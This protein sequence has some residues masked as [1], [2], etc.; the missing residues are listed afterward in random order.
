MLNN[1]LADI[2]LLLIKTKKYYWDVVG[3]QFRTL[4]VLWEERN[5]SFEHRIRGKLWIQGGKSERF[6]LSM[7]LQRG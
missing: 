1:C 5:S 3:L 2:Y 6:R 7:K 4:R